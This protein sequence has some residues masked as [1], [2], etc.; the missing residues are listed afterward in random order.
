MKAFFSKEILEGEGEVH[1][2]TNFRE[3][4]LLRLENQMLSK[5]RRLL[6]Q[7][8]GAAALLLNELDADTYE[9]YETAGLLSDYLRKLD[10]DELRHVMY[11]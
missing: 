11:G 1:D 9:T 3:I 7:L 5:E 8:A 6:M 2:V 10:V 4:H